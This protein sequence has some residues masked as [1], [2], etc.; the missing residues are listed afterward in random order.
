MPGPDKV[1]R[2]PGLKLRPRPEV[3]GRG[4]AGE[5]RGE[6][7]AKGQGQRGTLLAPPPW[8]LSAV[9][10]KTTGFFQN[11]YCRGPDPVVRGWRV[12]GVEQRHRHP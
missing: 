1:P 5:T 9:W 12:P 7:E 8:P 4:R 3:E 2:E 11:G 6:G 10:R